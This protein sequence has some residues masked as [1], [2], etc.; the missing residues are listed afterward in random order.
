MSE[1]I[2]VSPGSQHSHWR[3]T[4]ENEIFGTYCINYNYYFFPALLLLSLML[5]LWFLV[6]HGGRWVIC[7]CARVYVYVYPLSL[8]SSLFV[9]CF[10]VF[11]ILPYLS[12]ILNITK[13]FHTHVVPHLENGVRVHRQPFLQ[14][15]TSRQKKTNERKEFKKRHT[16]TP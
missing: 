11:I 6:N 7:L 12:F 5:E 10:F 4:G 13:V 3:D 14:F 9:L 8:F 15:V 1:N 16:N 2:A